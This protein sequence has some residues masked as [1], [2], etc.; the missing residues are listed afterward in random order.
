MRTKGPEGAYKFKIRYVDPDCDEDT[1]SR[2]VYGDETTLT[3]FDLQ[4]RKVEQFDY[5]EDEILDLLT[6]LECWDDGT[7]DA[8]GEAQYGS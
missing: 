7:Y 2:V 4:G 5:K 3:I 1:V 8:E 6:E